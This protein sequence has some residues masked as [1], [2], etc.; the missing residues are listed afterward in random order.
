[1]KDN[2]LAAKLEAILASGATYK[3]VAKRA[4]CDASTIYRIR[5]GAVTNPSYSVGC[6]IDAMHAE[7]KPAAA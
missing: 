4:G 2:D 1:M 3:S 5:T 6:A 7:L